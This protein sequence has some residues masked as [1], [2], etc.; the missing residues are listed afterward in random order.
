MTM[1]SA[2]VHR[3]TRRVVVDAVGELDLA[4]APGL[5]WSLDHYPANSDAQLIVDMS[6][7][8]FIDCAGLRPLLETRNRWGDQ[9]AL[10]DPSRPVT[11]L[12]DLLDLNGR[13]E[14]QPRG[15]SARR[16]E[17]CARHFLSTQRP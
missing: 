3:D 12:L 14:I 10:R 13:F 17:L 6:G 2:A 15:T 4:T 1:S 7:V 5:R 11:R 9:M 16:A 8:T